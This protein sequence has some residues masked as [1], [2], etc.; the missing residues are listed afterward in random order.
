MNF[1]NLKNLE[2]NKFFGKLTF[3]KL[4]QKF[5]NTLQDYEQHIGPASAVK[6]M[7]DFN[8]AGAPPSIESQMRTFEQIKER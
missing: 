1:F 4:V 2:L 8:P 3:F 7:C 5:K 6:S